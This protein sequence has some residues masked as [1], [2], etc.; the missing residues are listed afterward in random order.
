LCDLAAQN[1]AAVAYQWYLQGNIIAGATTRFF[2]VS[3]SGYYYVKIND[4]LGCSAQSQDTFV[5]YPNC[6]STGIE[7]IADYSEFEVYP[8]PVGSEITVS[9][10]N[11]NSSVSQIEILDLVGQV[12]YQSNAIN[13]LNAFKY[14]INT[15]NLSSGAYLLKVTNRGGQFAVKRLVKL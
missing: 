10:A 13:G 14:L 12:V 15:N 3:Q 5:S 9:F 6:L 7:A 8:N 4:T 2:T 11:T 1:I